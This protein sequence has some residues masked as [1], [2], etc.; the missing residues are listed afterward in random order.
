MFVCVDLHGDLICDLFQF[1]AGLAVLWLSGEQLLFECEQLNGCEQR[2]VD[3]PRPAVLM[4][5]AAVVWAVCVLP[6]G[7]PCW[8]I[9]L[10]CYNIQIF[11]KSSQ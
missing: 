11:L 10:C 6:H 9:L 8:H 1:A 3:E 5:A 2:A 7:S 4:T